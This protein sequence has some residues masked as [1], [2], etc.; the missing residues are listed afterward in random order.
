[1]AQQSLY[2][3]ASE[4]N[5]EK[6]MKEIKRELNEFPGVHSVSVNTNNG[7]I[8][9]DFDTTGV[10]ASEITGCLKNLG[11]SLHSEHQINL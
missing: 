4:A 2:F 6:D 11:Y 7:L 3:T 5:S 9:V 8:A 1:M 10:K